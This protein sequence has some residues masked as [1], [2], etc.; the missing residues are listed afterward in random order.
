MEKKRFLPFAS[1]RLMV[2]TMASHSSSA[3]VLDAAS[4]PKMLAAKAGSIAAMQLL[5][6]TKQCEGTTRFVGASNPQSP[7]RKQYR[8]FLKKEAA[9]SK[10][11]PQWANTVQSISRK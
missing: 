4:V 3:C 8:G 7:H 6:L 2:A 1:M 5:L 11:Y 10:K 9:A